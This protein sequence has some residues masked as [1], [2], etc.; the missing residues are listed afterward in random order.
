MVSTEIFET[1]IAGHVHRDLA[2]IFTFT[3]TALEQPTGRAAAGTDQ[4]IINAGQKIISTTLSSWH[5]RI[6]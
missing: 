5:G 4:E 1:E 6:L 3:A 2:G